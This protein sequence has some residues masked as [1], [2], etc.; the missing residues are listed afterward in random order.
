MT[1]TNPYENAQQVINKAADILKLEPWVREALL[2]THRELK[3]TFPVKMDD[4]SVK[5][6]TGY[7][8][9][10]NH[11]MGPFK[12]GIRYHWNVNLDEVRALATWMT[13]KCS[14][15][16]IPLGGGKGGVVCNPKDMSEAELERMTRGFVRRIAPLIGPHIDIPAPD[17][18]TN[19]KIMGWIADEY[20]KC[21][22]KPPLAVVTGK[23][24]DKGGS[25]GRHEATALGGFYVLNKIIEKGY[26]KGVD[27]IKGKSVVVQGFG[28]AGSI[29]AVFVHEAG[30]KVIAVSDSKGAIFNENGL[31]IPAV[32]KHKEKN[33]SVMDFVGSANTTNES[34]LELECDILVPAAL[35]NVITMENADKI[36]T[37]AILELANGPVTT[38]ADNLLAKKG[39]LVIPDVLA[40]A[41][42]VTVS[43]FEW[44]Q[45]LAEEHWSKEEVN[46]KLKEIMD[47]NTVLVMETAKKHKVSPRL[48]AY[49]LSIS[50][51]AE[52]ADHELSDD[53]C[54]YH[55]NCI[56]KREE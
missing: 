53:S 16:N 7:R 15:V 1:Q 41:G 54:F 5:N 34:I 21:L 45:N 23:P 18:Y 31:D 50:R 51:I 43:Y 37:K 36:K 9:Q 10:H 46:K 52:K 40:N 22:A 48:G 24:L 32:I 11:M 6:F 47:E 28:N 56:V 17:V 8:I 13:I 4:G 42:G 33:G 44:K 12:G 25:E 35:E 2:S 14:V 27:S 26:L 49:V 19:A 3:V 20:G 38:S 39:I 29:F 30:A 55:E